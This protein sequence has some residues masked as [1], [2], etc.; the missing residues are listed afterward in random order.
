MLFSCFLSPHLWTDWY[1]W[2][3]VTWTI[4][5]CWHCNAWVKWIYMHRTYFEAHM[6][7]VSNKASTITCLPLHM[8]HT[9]A[10]HHPLLIAQMGA[11]LATTFLELQTEPSVSDH[12]CQ[13]TDC[14]IYARYGCMHDIF[15]WCCYIAHLY[16]IFTCSDPSSITLH[17][18]SVWVI[19]SFMYIWW[20][21]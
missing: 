20:R 13:S 9:S 1:C 5:K 6:K 17:C 21:W 8:H 2:S 12:L 18:V 3:A 7:M 11:S 16:T 14:I 19:M 4:E 15:S 10:R